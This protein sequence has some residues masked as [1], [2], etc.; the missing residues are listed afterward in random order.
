MSTGN[1][2]DVRMMGKSCAMTCHYITLLY[3]VYFVVV[4]THMHHG[5][6]LHTYVGTLVV[7]SFLWKPQ[8][9]TSWKS[10]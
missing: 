6:A 1:P 2:W 10:C 3:R 4:R 8:A 5:A 7:G 9:N